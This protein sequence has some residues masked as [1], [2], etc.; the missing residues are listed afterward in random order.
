MIG[1]NDFIID[2][3]NFVARARDVGIRFLRASREGA[4]EIARSGLLDVVLIDLSLKGGDAVALSI[5]LRAATPTLRTVALGSD[6]EAGGVDPSARVQFDGF[7]S[8]SASLEELAD[9]ILGV[10]RSPGASTPR[11]T[12]EASLITI[13]G[14]DEAAF[15]RVAGAQ[16][17]FR[18][19]EILAFLVQ[20]AGS[21]EIAREL[22]ITRNTLR[23]H[24]Q[25]VMTKLQV[26]SRLQAVMFARA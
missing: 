13:D 21:E 4:L 20:G 3:L 19:H 2:A 10:K 7:L 12:D 17:T 23:T 11:L 9:A 24:I 15:A 26:H 5:A 18:E 14:Y 22:D 16:L 1:D 25:N 8:K 6:E